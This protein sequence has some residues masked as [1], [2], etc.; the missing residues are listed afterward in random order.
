MKKGTVSLCGIKQNCYLLDTREKVRQ[1]SKPNRTIK[2]YNS[3]EEIQLPNG[4]VQEV[5]KKDYPINSDTITSYIESSDYRLDP[6]SAIQ[7]APKR[8]NLGDVSQVQEF[9]N[10]NPIEATRQYADVLG[11]VKAYF[12]SV[13]NAQEKAKVQSQSSSQEV[14]NG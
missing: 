6:M 3:I 1:T 11:K 12:E 14:N 8:V 13:A 7:N 10:S 5:V 4:F 2:Q 9:V